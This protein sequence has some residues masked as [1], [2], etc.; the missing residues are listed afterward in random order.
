MGAARVARSGDQQRDEYADSRRRGACAPL[1]AR[2]TIGGDSRHI[3]TSLKVGAVLDGTVRSDGDRI[4]VTAEL[5][6]ARQ[7]S[8]IWHEQYERP[9]RDVF[10]GQDEISRAIAG[11]LQVTRAS[12]GTGTRGGTSDATAYDLYLKG[13]YLVRPR[14]AVNAVAATP[15][16]RSIPQP[17]GRHRR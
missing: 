9:A 8:V 14:E 10:G 13:M 17:E 5:S 3:G 2:G 1:V 12:A 7:G 15:R 11:Q 6:D 4:R 16:D